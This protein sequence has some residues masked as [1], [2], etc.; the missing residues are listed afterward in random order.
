[1]SSTYRDALAAE[2][3]ALK[4]KDPRILVIDIETSP[5]VAYAW[6]LWDQ[7]ISTSQLIEP[8]R[9]LCFAAK[10]MG[11]RKVMFHGE[12]E[13]RSEMVR[14]AWDLL[15]EADIVVGYNHIRFDIP[16]L[17]REFILA[18]LPPPSPS[19]NI[20]LLR[21]NRQRFKFASNK[22][23]Y[24]TEVLG[25]ETKL[26]TGGQ[27]LWNGVLA[28][29]EKSWKTFIRYNKQDVIIT[30][31]LFGILAPWINGPH[32]GLWYGNLKGCHACQSTALM[33]Q[34]F[35]YAKAIAY[36]KMRCADCGAVNK[37]LRNGQ[38]RAA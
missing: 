34:G 26:E 3:E 22:L 31:Q 37:L 9:V 38:T 12:R 13:G 27:S 4:P 6:G 17:N 16:H 36:P 2:L 11:V 8:S 28:G 21:V 5:N 33:P 7:N 20:D 35:L 30:E 1:M 14:A 32:Q 10:W 29:D 19:M 23:G 25:L 24:V 15:D 18:G